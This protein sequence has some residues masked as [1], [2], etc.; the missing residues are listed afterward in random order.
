M[1]PRVA[2]VVTTYDSPRALELVLAGLSV[3]TEPHFE[4]VV[5]DDGSGP[6]TADVVR[7]WEGRVGLS[8]LHVRQERRGFR[9][10]AIRNRSILATRAPYVVFL[11]GDC[12][13]DRR[14]VADHLS[15]AAPGCFVQGHRLLLGPVASSALRVEDVVAGRLPS[16]LGISN[17]QNLVRLPHALAER[18]RRKDRTDLRGIRTANFA[19]HR[20]DLLRVGGFDETYEGWGRE[21]ADLAARLLH[22]GVRRK[23]GRFAAV[24]RHLYHPPRSRDS[25]PENDARLAECLRTRR[26]RAVRGLS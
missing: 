15:M 21:D 22:A 8:L 6:E 9:A 16:L 1:T 3:Q 14:F 26:V 17:R 5:A 18:L 19:V 25:L 20:A 13:P 4:A 2:V 7:R 11:D 23:E 24:V 10:A 12:V